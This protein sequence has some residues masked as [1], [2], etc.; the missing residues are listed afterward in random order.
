MRIKNKIATALLAVCCLATATSAYAFSDIQDPRQENIAS[1][2]QSQGIIHGVA[3][4]RFAPSEKLSAAQGVQ[5]LVN[6]MNLKAANGGTASGSKVNI[7]EN[8]WY[9]QA[10]GI[11]AD[12][13]IPISQIRDWSSKLTKEQF[14]G[15]LHKAVTATG[16]YPIVEM[17]LAVA[18]D[19]EILS[20]NKGAVQF[21]LLTHI[22]KLDEQ[23]NFH[24]KQY[25][26]RMEAAEMIYN[27]R[28]FI[29]SKGPQDPG[30]S[31]NDVSV[32]VKKINDDVNQVILSKS[33]MPNPGYGI[34]VDRIEFISGQKAVAYYHFTTPE[35]GKI[36]P[37]VIST[38]KASF[39]VDSKYKV[40][41]IQSPGQVELPI[42][43][44][45]I[46]K[47]SLK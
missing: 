5:L 7:P 34:V 33:D 17:Y 40:S 35:P 29:Q 20:E 15:M 30:E 25:I 26:S 31:E 42:S 24:P 41:V 11:A 32:Q 2:L 1:Y 45:G 8:A 22:A 19:D 13:G 18:D 46:D 4:D 44:P 23:Q 43:A 27:A 39:Y 37:Q 14:A 10:A 3:P 21:L 38:A 16:E 47:K 12:N 6:A 9:A 28:Q 36:Y